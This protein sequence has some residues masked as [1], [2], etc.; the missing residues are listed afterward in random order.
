[1]PG[2]RMQKGI[3]VWP[4]RVEFTCAELHRAH[5]AFDAGQKKEALH[6]LKLYLS[7][8]LVFARER[9]A[10]CRQVRGDDAPMLICEGCGVARF[11][12]SDHQRM[13]SSRTVR[14]G[15]VWE[16]RHKDICGVLRTWRQVV[17]GVD[18]S[19]L[20]SFAAEMPNRRAAKSVYAVYN[21]PDWCTADLLAFLQH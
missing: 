14:G 13:A 16:G 4:S 1:M 8:C 15:S 6:H 17:K 9:C 3:S 7:R 2:C 5:L 21:T 10:G 11:C 18:S 19:I 12:N 20:Q